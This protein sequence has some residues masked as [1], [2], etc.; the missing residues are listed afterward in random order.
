[1]ATTLNG[2]PADLPQKR[3]TIPG[4]TRQITCSRDFGPLLL[5]VCADYD[6]TV[7]SIDSGDTVD[8]ASLC[9]RDA[10]ASAGRLSNHSNGTAVDLNWSEEGAQN[11]NWGRKFFAGAKAAAAIAVIKARYGSCIR[12][13]GDWRA[14]D[15]MHWEIKPGVTL[16]KARKLQAKL[17]IDANGNRKS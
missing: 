11:S 7:R 13:G 3:F 17:G 4:T 14:K 5:A 6:K 10:R 12:W 15:F 8:D 16:E 1:M 9:K 2:L